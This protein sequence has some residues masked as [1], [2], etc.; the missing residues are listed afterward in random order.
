MSRIYMQKVHVFETLK[1]AIPQEIHLILVMLVLLY[2]LMMLFR[3]LDY[4]TL[5]ETVM[6]NM[7]LRIQGS[8]CSLF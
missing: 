8:G 4:E 5:N 2:C 7:N 6:M 3:C 1:W